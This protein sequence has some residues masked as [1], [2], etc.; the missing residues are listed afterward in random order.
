MCEKYLGMSRVLSTFQVCKT[1]ELFYADINFSRKFSTNGANQIIVFF[2]VCT[3]ERD[4][5][6]FLLSTRKI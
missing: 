1:T 3:P 4:I 6:E 2:N 5:N